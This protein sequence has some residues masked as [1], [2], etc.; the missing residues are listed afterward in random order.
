MEKTNCGFCGASYSVEKGKCPICGYPRS[1]EKKIN[2]EDI[3]FDEEL[4]FLNEEPPVKKNKPIFNYD[5][6]NADVDEEEETEEEYEEEVE[7]E[8]SGANAALIVVLVV[9]IT[10]LL[11]ATGFVFFRFFLPNIMGTE[12]TTVP[13][14]E[15]I[16]LET[17]ESTNPTIP[18]KMLAL[19]SEAP[20]LNQEGQPWLLHVT[21]TPEDTTDVLSYISEDEAV[22]TVSEDGKIIAVGEGET[23]IKIICGDQAI[24]CPVVVDYD[25]VIEESTESV[26]PSMGVDETE[27]T[28]APTEITEETHATEATQATEPETTTEASEPSGSVLKLKETDISLSKV[29]GI[30]YELTMDCDIPA[31]QVEWITMNSNVLLVKDGVITVL[32]PGTTKVVAKYN[33]QTVECIVRC[34]F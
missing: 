7:E 18:C 5:E 21:V 32:G 19:T 20:K 30:T 13:T 14:T 22:V 3:S 29:R 4:A 25:M 16:L 15:E 33:G 31:S 27:E 12:E 23:I 2:Q 8:E 34:V 24:K 28:S 11:L 9:I 17:E 10:L 1:M 26:V 6:V